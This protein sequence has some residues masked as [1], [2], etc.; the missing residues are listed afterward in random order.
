MQV[1][2]AAASKLAQLAKIDP[3]RGG[4]HR[5]DVARRSCNDDRLC[6]F[7][8]RDTERLRLSERGLR[9]CVRK[10]LITH[11][12]LVEHSGQVFGG[13][14]RSF[15]RIIAELTPAT[16]HLRPV[17]RDHPPG[18]GGGGNRTGSMPTRRT[19]FAGAMGRTERC[20]NLVTI[21]AEPLTLA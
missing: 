14:G 13:H 12:G 19:E 21:A 5:T 8:G 15:L 4:K 16:A 1:F 11:A 9:A 7:R 2:G 6:H 17:V 3:L 10:K 20:A 18:R